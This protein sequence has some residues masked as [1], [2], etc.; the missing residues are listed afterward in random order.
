MF[1]RIPFAR[2]S[3][4]LASYTRSSNMSNESPCSYQ[5]TSMP[6]SDAG[7]AGHAA[8]EPRLVALVDRRPVVVEE[9]V[10]TFVVNKEIPM[11]TAGR[12]GRSSTQNQSATSVPPKLQRR[13][14]SQPTPRATYVVVSLHSTPGVGY[15]DPSWRKTSAGRV[16]HGARAPTVRSNDRPVQSPPLEVPV[17]S[18]ICSFGPRQSAGRGER[19]MGGEGAGLVI[20]GFGQALLTVADT[21][22]PSVR[23]DT[24]AAAAAARSTRCSD[25]PMT[26]AGCGAVQTTPAAMARARPKTSVDFM[27]G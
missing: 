1:A 17:H 7:R 11:G 3:P 2:S 16:K 21:T 10:N 23:L 25:L 20:G 19:A 26:T 9:V 14:E 15:T 22:S 12:R 24:T 27:V 5:P 18:S 13:G 4:S 8:N 6:S